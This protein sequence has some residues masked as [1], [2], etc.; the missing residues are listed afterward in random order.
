DP[1]S[2]QLAIV[3]DVQVGS[4]QKAAGSGTDVGAMLAP[5]PARLRGQDAHTTAGETSYGPDTD[6]GPPALRID[7]NGDL[8]VGSDGGEGVFH[9][10]IIYQPATYD[11]QRTRNQEPRT[12]NKE[13]IEGR[14][15]LSGNRVTFEVAS[16]D[17]TRPLII[18]PV[19]AYSTYLGGSGA[20]EGA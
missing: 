4:Q 16:Y 13:L 10:P 1:R 15:I 19:L 18:D 7:G 12:T 5:P 2:V 8:V 20:D 9:K 11:V 14:Y 17:R 6:V 3:S